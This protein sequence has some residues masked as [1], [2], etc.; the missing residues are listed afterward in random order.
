MQAASIARGGRRGQ[1]GFTLRPARRIDTA[2]TS[3]R[4]YIR[5]SGIDNARKKPA[6][7]NA[8]IDK[9]A[10]RNASAIAVPISAG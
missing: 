4:A 2:A 1:L 9:K 3:R 7:V 6:V 8:A 10:I 5:R